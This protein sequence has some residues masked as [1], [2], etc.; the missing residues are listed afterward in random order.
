MYHFHIKKKCKLK[1]ALLTR[2]Q[3]YDFWAFWILAHDMKPRAF[4]G[5]RKALTKVMC[6]HIDWSKFSTKQ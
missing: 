1:S 2:P 6:D 3:A 4:M 5:G